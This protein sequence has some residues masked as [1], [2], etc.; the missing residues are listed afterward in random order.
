MKAYEGVDIQIHTFFISALV[1]RELSASP[2]GRFN[3][4]THWTGA[5]AQPVASRYTD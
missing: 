4:G 3:P 2:T 1:G 5:V